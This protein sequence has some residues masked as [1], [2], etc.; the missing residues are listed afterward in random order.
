MKDPR[1]WWLLAAPPRPGFWLVSARIGP[2]IWGPAVPA[3]VMRVHTEHEPG[4][5]DNRMDRSPFWAAFV[6]D[7]PTRIW[8]LQQATHTEG[9]R[10]YRTIR[11]IDEAEY[12]FLVAETVWSRQYAPDEPAARPHDAVNLRQIPIPF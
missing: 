12:R 4:E 5:P 8:S 1:P 2:R 6:A 9:D 10:I 3:A 7:E 11:E